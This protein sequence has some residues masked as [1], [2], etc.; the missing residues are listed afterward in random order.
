MD[1]ENG[2]KVAVRYLGHAGK[3]FIITSS[4][5][6]TN[7]FSTTSGDGIVRLSD[8]R[9]PLPKVSFD[10]GDQS[11]HI[12]TALYVHVA[13]IPMALEGSRS[14]CR[15]FV[16]QSWHTSSQRVII[17]WL[18]WL[19]MPN[20]RRSMPL[21]SARIWIGWDIIMTIVR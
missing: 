16:F 15:T 14:K 11:E 18:A 17:R 19:G 9:E 1:L 7:A 4:P 10:I 2:G 8:V 13:G 5:D 6:D 3:V 20:A 12:F 21:P